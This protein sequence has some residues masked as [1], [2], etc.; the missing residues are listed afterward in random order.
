MRSF[1]QGLAATLLMMSSGFAGTDNASQAL[2]TYAASLREKFPDVP[3]ITT[4]ELAAF[5]PGERPVLLDAR[6]QREFAVS[7][8][9]GALRAESDVFAQLR[10]IG[11]T[12]TTP[13]VVYCSV[14]Y[15]SALLARELQKA[16]FVHVRNLEGSIFAWANEGRPL[17]NEGGPTIGVHPF[18]FLW[19]RYLDQSYRRWKPDIPATR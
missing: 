2:S 11:A 7:H 12:E 3:V 5:A 15:R 13:I 16:G 17:V 9:P 14:G 19:S 10:N 6:E 1:C 18:N 4:G 8:L